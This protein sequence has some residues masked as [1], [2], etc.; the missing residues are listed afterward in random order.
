LDL[1]NKQKANIYAAINTFSLFTSG[2]KKEMTEYLDQFY[3]TINDPSDVKATF[4]TNA[5]KQ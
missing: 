4:I 2:S 5:R 3:R 1:F